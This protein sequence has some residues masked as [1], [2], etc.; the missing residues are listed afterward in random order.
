[1]IIQKPEEQGRVRELEKRVSQLEKALAQVTLDKLMLT[2]TLEVAE[3]EYGIE[4][5]KRDERPLSKEHKNKRR[6]KR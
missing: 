1:M 2:A 4:L 3:Q 5:K 6:G